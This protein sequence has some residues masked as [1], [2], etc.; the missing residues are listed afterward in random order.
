MAKKNTKKYYVVWKGLQP[1]VYDTWEACKRQVMGFDKALYKSFETHEAA[2]RAYKDHP[3]R[4]IGQ[5]EKVSKVISEPLAPPDPN[6]ISVDGACNG[7]T[8]EAEYRGVYTATGQELFAAGP[9]DHASNNIVE[10]LAIVHAL[11]YCKQRQLTLPIYSDSKTA[12]SWVRRK[13]IKTTVKPDDKNRKVFEL[14]ARALEWLRTHSYSNP[15][16]KWETEVWGEIKADYGR[17]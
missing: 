17:K 2:L 8:G 11:A 16:L 9:F 4:Y 15:I 1:G 5:Q 7:K 6:S 10:F 3:Y 12:I 14:I 13:N